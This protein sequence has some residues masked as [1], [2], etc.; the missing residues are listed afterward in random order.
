MTEIVPAA[1]AQGA[2]AG[3]RVP[4]ESAAPPASVARVPVRV[5]IALTARAAGVTIDDLRSTCRRHE[6][7]RVRQLA[8]WIARTY[9]CPKAWDGSLPAIGRCIRRDHTTVL[10]AMRATARRLPR[11]AALRDL[12]DRALARIANWRQPSGAAVHAPPLVPPAEPSAALPA[13]P[14]G[15]PALVRPAPAGAIPPGAP[16]DLTPAHWY[17]ATADDRGY[18]RRQDEAFQRAMR[19][20]GCVERAPEPCRIASLLAAAR[21]PTD[22]EAE[23]QREIAALLDRDGIAYVREAKVA[24][25]RIDFLAGATAAVGLGTGVGIEAKV[26]G[27]RRAIFRQ[28]AAYCA[29][30]RIV[31]LIVVS[32]TALD[33]PAEIH[34]KPVTVVRTGRAWL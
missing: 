21:L 2:E 24:G 34:R 1:T 20:K 3:S 9:R 14:C 16:D 17:G 23:L 27:G 4:A 29:D 11:D 22:T 12:R 33:L 18:I 13:K 8:A 10:H 26:A 28:C 30:P 7:V 15:S 32:G 6:L 31:K 25:G 19:A 5:M